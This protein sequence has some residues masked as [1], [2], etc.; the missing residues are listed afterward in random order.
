MHAAIRRYQIDPEK[1]PEVIQLILEGFVPLIRKSPGVLAY[2]VL[3]AQDGQFATL[4]V[5]DSQ[6]AV[7]AS[8]KL[9]SDWIKQLLASRVLSQDRLYRVFVEVEETL[10]QQTT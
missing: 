9:A 4:S 7:E 3:D 10:L 5:F 8:N 6:A 2:Y 1:A